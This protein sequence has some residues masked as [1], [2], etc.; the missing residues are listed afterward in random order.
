MR[1]KNVIILHLRS[2]IPC[3]TGSKKKGGD[4]IES[5]KHPTPEVLNSFQKLLKNKIK[6]R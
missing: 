1:L 4:K 3:R 2:L 6:M 5:C